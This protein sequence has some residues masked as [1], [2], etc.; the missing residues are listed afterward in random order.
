MPSHAS[1]ILSV[2]HRLRDHRLYLP[3]QSFANPDWEQAGF[4]VLIIR[5][6][7]FADVERSTPHL[8]LAA[9]TR[10]V[11]PDAFIDMAFLPT[12]QD[13][14]ALREAG[15]PLL[16][17]TQSLRTLEDF[18]LALVSNAWLLEQVNLPFLLVHSGVP[19][20][21]SERGEEWP[22]L[23]L[24]G[25]NST[26]A[27][28]LVS[29]AG[30]CM[31][32]AI[33]F[34]E[35]EGAVGRIAKLCRD[36]RALGKRERLRRA[37]EEVPGLWP[38]GNLGTPVR[39]A[40]AAEEALV[41]PPDAPPAPILPGPEA[42]T[43]RLSITRGCPCLCSFCFEGF[44]RKPWRELPVASL[45]EAAR[46]MKKRGADTVEVDSF[47]FNA[48]AGLAPLLAG[49]HRL[50]LHVNLMS[51]RVDIL[52]RTPGMIDLEIAAG[53][54]SFTLG[55]EG[56][57]ESVR[58]FLHKSISA[59]DITRVLEDLHA[60]KTREIKLFYMLT[61][62]EAAAD[63]AELAGFARDL[64][65][66]RERARSLPRIVFSFGMLV[67]MP[68]TPLRYDAPVLE[69]SAWRQVVGRVRSVCETA[70]FEFRLSLPWADYAAT[71]ALAA[72][73]HD[74]HRLLLRLAEEGPVTEA[75]LGPRAADA[76]QEWVAG[77]GSELTGGRPAEHRFAFPFLDDE[78]TRAMLYRLYQRARAGQDTGYGLLTRR[79]AETGE[80]V[81]AATGELRALMGR[82][83]RLP[84]VIAL[85]RLPREAAGMGTQWAEACVMRSLLHEHPEEA[86]NLLSVRECLVEKTGILG[87][88]L[89]W[90]GVAIAKLTAWDASLLRSHLGAAIVE[91]EPG[92]ST[93][94]RLT[95]TLPAEYWAHPAESLAEHLRDHHAPVTLS[96]SAGRMRFIAA[97]RSAKKRMLLSGSCRTEGDAH[98]LELT[99]GSK[100]FIGEW[101]SATAEPGAVRRALA[102]IQEIS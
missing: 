24:G 18:D 14:A 95:L 97:E 1:T 62:R 23:I 31:A 98:V 8:F 19:A 22:P 32:D 96:R 41:T 7:P 92:A 93:T 56:I 12:A 59:R 5:L 79:L 66:I 64:R 90:H 52:A 17:G 53:K 15:I 68:F 29:P 87:P 33:F 42:A 2:R 35:G 13:A 82:K 47:T 30:D 39:K 34:G 84:P 75:G 55:I 3:N 21:S 60:R 76:V 11:L 85:V 83:R 57:S 37:A 26:A 70:G 81:R 58:A 77:R 46:A 101:L 51:Q 20:W 74:V 36:G 50:F 65:A 89:P 49:L 61:G 38:A 28:A 63:V 25:S 72:G 9:E 80:G 6:S 71:Q 48:H 4:R 78:K 67:R 27:H 94:V 43:A 16:V 73:G 100:P 102:E 10:A 88:D 45:L 99:V 91:G 54:S 86:D 44:D 40:R 69:E